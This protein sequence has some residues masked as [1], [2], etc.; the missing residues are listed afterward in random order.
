MPGIL[1][2]S[3]G[4]LLTLTLVER[5]GTVLESPIDVDSSPPAVAVETTA[6][7]E[8]PRVTVRAAKA[9][10][11]PRAAASTSPRATRPRPRRRCES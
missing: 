5:N 6:V 10:A 3:T 1:K 4:G 7:L 9:P 2:A 8:S 11:T